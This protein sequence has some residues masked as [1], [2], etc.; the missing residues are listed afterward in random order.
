LVQI[1]RYGISRHGNRPLIPFMSYSG[2]S[3]C[4]LQAII[5]FLRTLRPVLSEASPNKLGG[6]RSSAVKW[7]MKS[8]A[9]E[10]PP[11]ECMA[12]TRT[13]EYGQYLVFSV[14][15]CNGCH[16]RRSKL[17]GAF[18]G[19]PLAGGMAIED[20]GRTFRPPN[21]TPIS[22]GVMLK[23]TE[24]TFIEYFRARASLPTRSP[25]PWREFGRMSDDGLG[26]I[27]RYLRTLPPFPAGA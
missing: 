24:T 26:A 1:L 14:A 21:L 9:P 2:M 15:N 16:T 13:A 3:D 18:V 7:L 23:F 5:S 6:L 19:T 8:Q 11:P 25:M 20:G 12:P 4:D 17:T 27:F 22:D 10:G